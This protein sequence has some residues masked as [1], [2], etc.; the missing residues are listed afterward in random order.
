MS[1]KNIEYTKEIQK[2]G[3]PVNMSECDTCIEKIDKKCKKDINKDIIHKY[4]HNCKYGS[5]YIDVSSYANNDNIDY[6]Y[7][8]FDPNEKD[9]V[10]RTLN[11]VKE[12]CNVSIREINQS[13]A[14]STDCFKANAYQDVIDFIEEHQKKCHAVEDPVV[15][16]SELKH[17]QNEIEW[18]KSRM[19]AYRKSF[20]K[21][22]DIV[23]HSDS[24]D[25]IK[26]LVKEEKDRY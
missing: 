25:I 11:M 5:N 4:E 24:P 8:L 1:D 20:F 7:S 15:E 17:I 6:S 3:Q 12:Y 23:E 9:P 14:I 18:F 22:C 19:D 26:K 21:V 2:F 10:M 13:R 16:T